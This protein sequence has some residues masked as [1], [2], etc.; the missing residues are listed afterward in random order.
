MPPGARPVFSLKNRRPVEYKRAMAIRVMRRC[1]LGVSSLALLLGPAACSTSV[2]KAG[3]A[4][5]PAQARAK[6]PA[7]ADAPAAAFRLRAGDMI[8]VGVWNHTDTSRSVKINPDG[9]VSLP[10]VG[11]VRA[12]GLTPEELRDQLTLKYARFFVDPRVDVNVQTLGGG[13]KVY[14]IGEVEKPGSLTLDFDMTAWE[15]VAGSGGFSDDAN[16]SRALLIR[17]ENGQVNVRTLKLAMKSGAGE[18]ESGGTTA[19]QSGDI[20]YVL[21]STMVNMERFMKR[22]DVILAPLI[23]LER[24]IVLWPDARDVLQGKDNKA[25]G[26]GVILAQ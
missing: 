7:P 6:T 15:A 8:D 10:L 9:Y 4:A 20:V 25:E 14:V 13:R 19:L 16:R 26:Q 3:K 24:G 23:S 1:V 18:G 12:A 17:S 22:L 2:P 11:Q 5:A 21:P